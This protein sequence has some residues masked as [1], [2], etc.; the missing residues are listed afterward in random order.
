MGRKI[1][2]LTEL[3]QERLHSVSIDEVGNQYIHLENGVT[4]Y[5]SPALIVEANRIIK[6]RE[7]SK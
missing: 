6:E 3:S 2:V 5:L 1:T 4:I 7:E